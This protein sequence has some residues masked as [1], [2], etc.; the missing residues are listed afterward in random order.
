M[1]TQGG[2]GTI[3]GNDVPSYVPSEYISYVQAAANHLGIP[4][5]VVA[6]QIQLES[7]FLSLIHI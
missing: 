7:S 6:A 3:S 5:A 2:L 1:P 4:A